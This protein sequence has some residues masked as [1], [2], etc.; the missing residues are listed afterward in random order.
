[1]AFAIELPI[2]RIFLG[3]HIFDVCTNH[4]DHRQSL[5]TTADQN[6]SFQA[7]FIDNGHLFGGPEWKL[8]SRRGESLSLDKRFHPNEWPAE[9]VED[10]I[11]RFETKCSSSPFDIIQNV[12]RCWYSGDVD[13]VVEPLVR[14]L[15]MLRVLF[16]EELA[17]KRMTSKLSHVN[18]T[19]AKL[20]LHRFELPFY[21]NLKK[22]PTSCFTS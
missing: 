15:S 16:L 3:I 9:T 5:F 10:W 2:L 1:M 12:P 7:V 18:L 13:Q 6:V 19:D 17:R 21:G 11:A 8:K 4:C 22:R 20:S 14:R